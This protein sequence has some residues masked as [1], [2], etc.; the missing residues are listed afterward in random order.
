MIGKW[1]RFTFIKQIKRT[2]RSEFCYTAPQPV[3]VSNNLSLVKL[4]LV[5]AIMTKELHA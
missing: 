1:P 3:V 4:C 2:L 5:N